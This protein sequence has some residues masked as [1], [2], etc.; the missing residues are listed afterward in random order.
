MLERLFEEVYVKFKLHFYQEIFERF[1]MREASLTTVETFAMETIQA[2]GSPT[3]NEFATFM[4]ISPPNAAYKVNS[5]IKK[6]YV[7][8]VQSQADKREYH[9]EVTEKY[10]SY[11]NISSDYVKTV[12]GRMRQRFSPE[13]QEK[14][15]E[16]LQVI[17]SEL[18]PEVSEGIRL[19]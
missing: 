3:V 8:K 19:P 14:L 11:Y 12:V 7:R 13:E 9:L 1:Q 18:M 16:M 5:L 2:L 15:T 4:R 17:T 6:G 10:Q